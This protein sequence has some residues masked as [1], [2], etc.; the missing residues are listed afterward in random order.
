[1]EMEKALIIT[2]DGPSGVGKSTV[3][4]SVAK[5]LGLTYLDTGA[6][7]RAIALQVKRNPLNINN[8]E[9]LSSLLAN[10][11]IKFV[12]NEDNVLIISLNDEDITD[13]IRSP[14]ISRLSSDVATKSL[15]RKKLVEIQKE[16]GLNSNIV[17]EGRD[18]GTYVF[19]DAKF[20]FYLDATIEERVKRRRNQLIQSGNNIGADNM[21]KEIELRDKQD[22]ERLESPLHPALNAV[23]IDTT[24]LI[25]DEV[26]N[27]IIA[28]VKGE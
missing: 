11:D 28:E 1:M 4:K 22:K 8:D 7:Y 23:I 17:V 25:A 5:Y 24:N 10:T 15:V 9:E 26:V 3:A 13:K 19:P 18:M 16:I 2:I 20:K 14:E 21:L 6:M 27:R 12:N